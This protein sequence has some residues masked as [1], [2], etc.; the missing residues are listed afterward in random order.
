VDCTVQIP[1]GG[2]IEI[3]VDYIAGPFL[4]SDPAVYG[5]EAGDDFFFRFVNGSVLYGS[6]DLAN[7]D[8]VFLDGVDITD[9]VT[10]LTSLTRNDLIIDPDGPGGPD[11]AF[12][13]HLSCSDPFT[14]GWGQ[15]AGPVEGVDVNWQVAFFS[16]ARYNSG[17]GF[18]KNC[19]NVLIPFE[20]P[21]I[22][23]ATGTDS[24]ETQTVSDDATVTIA[25]GVTLDR[26]QTNG[27]RV[28]ARLINFSGEDKVFSDVQILWPDTPGPGSLTKVRLDNPVI[29]ESRSGVPSADPDY[30]I[31]DAAD[32]DWNGGT[33]LATQEEQILRFDFENKAAGYLYRVRVNFTDGTF[34]DLYLEL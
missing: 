32:P 13:M 25:P 17:S 21:N 14:G 10:I 26:L 29:W 1:A 22:G 16:I 12:E 8:G 20:V 4:S 15:S 9:Q 34:L 6:T 31:L 24:F 30:V 23:T 5:T 2:S 33:L 28:T 27:R 19:G 3:T 7:G 18:I 11:P